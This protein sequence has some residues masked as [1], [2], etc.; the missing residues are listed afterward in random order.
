MPYV[1]KIDSRYVKS[2]KED[3]QNIK[4]AK[5]FDSEKQAKTFAQTNV[6]GIPYKIIELHEVYDES[7]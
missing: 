6:A 4:Q 7:K 1:I 2:G 5:Q 3:T